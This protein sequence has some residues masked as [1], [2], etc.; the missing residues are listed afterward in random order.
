MLE[1][2]TSHAMYVCICQQ[3]TESQIRQLCRERGGKASAS[4]LREQFGLGLECGKC[5]SHARSILRE[6]QQSVHQ[7]ENYDPRLA[8]AV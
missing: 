6:Y 2:N 7:P 3:V 4:D 8:I 1:S 5:S